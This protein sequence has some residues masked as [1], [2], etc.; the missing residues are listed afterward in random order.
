V[1][2]VVLIAVVARAWSEEAPARESE[3]AIAAA[4]RD[5]AAIKTAHSGLEQPTLALPQAD[6]PA[7]DLKTTEPAEPLELR[8]RTGKLTREEK[9]RLRQKERSANWLLEAMN[10][11]K[12]S[13]RELGPAEGSHEEGAVEIAPRS[14]DFLA[15]SVAL[16]QEKNAQESRR[17]Q[18]SE[19]AGL[20]AAPAANPLSGYMASWLSPRDYELLK[21]ADKTPAAAGVPTSPASGGGGVPVS[22]VAMSLEAGAANP[23]DAPL[24]PGAISPAQNPYLSDLPLLP[25]ASILAAPA[26]AMTTFEAPPAT[27]PP[28]WTPAPES[29]RASSA[30][31][32]LEELIKS[33]DDEKYFKQLKRF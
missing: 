28:G 15:N 12:D 20:P 17:R 9:E 24:L 13:A 8:M 27:P 26:P 10:E 21:A 25:P 14:G 18:E 5:Y 16:L 7:L 23:E 31:S 32:P 19:T 22:D 11:Q 2:G 4:K 29:P 33:R 30:A 1:A 6:V 3:D